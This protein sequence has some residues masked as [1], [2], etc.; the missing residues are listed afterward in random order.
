MP[1]GTIVTGHGVDLFVLMALRAAVKLEEKGI[2]VSRRSATAIAKQRFSL[3]RGTL[4]SKVIIRINEEIE[5][6]QLLLKP[7]DIRNF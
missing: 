4:R 6:T 1:N 5:K 3:P 2:Q 7:G